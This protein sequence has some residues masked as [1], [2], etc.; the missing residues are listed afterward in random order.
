MFSRNSFGSYYPINSII[1]KLNP[2]IKIFNFLIVVILVILSNSIYINSFMLGLLIIMM[3]LSYVPFNYYF[4]TFWFLRYVYILIAFICAYFRT[5]MQF[6]LILIM[7]IV[8]VVEYI[9]LL[10]YTTS[11]HES[12]YGIEKFLSLFNIFYLP[13][14]KIAFKINSILRYY[15][16]MVGVEYSILKS[17]SSRGVNYY[18]TNI[19]KR[20][21]IFFKL[22]SSIQRKTRDK[23]RDILFESELRLFNLKRK[24]TIYRKNK[25]GFVDI[26]LLLFHLLFV[27]IYLSEKGIV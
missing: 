19:I 6:C 8:I 12:E 5:S 24:R 16:L 1:H 10:S 15:P 23:S 11:P 14:S 17:A 9:N 3:L 4:K 18:H 2:V 7:K 21:I 20:I 22:R 26:F 27:Y 13:V 25:V